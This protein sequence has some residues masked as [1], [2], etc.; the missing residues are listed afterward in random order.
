[1]KNKQSNID[2]NIHR[3]INSIID[4]DYAQATANLT[5]AVNEKIKSSMVTVLQET[6]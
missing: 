3:F 2:R 4:R 1:M 5:N 6:P